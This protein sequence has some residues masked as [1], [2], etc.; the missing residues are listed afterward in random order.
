LLK[1]TEEEEG[2]GAISVAVAVVVV[3][4]T[5]MVA[6][7]ELVDSEPVVVAE[8]MHRPAPGALVVWADSA[9]AEVA[10]AVLQISILRDH[11]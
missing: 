3:A 4:S 9:G 8:L 5:T 11:F 1:A 6:M 7:E 2:P 10:Q